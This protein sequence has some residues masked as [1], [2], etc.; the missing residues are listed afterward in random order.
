[1]VSGE[2]FSKNS[3]ERMP[4]SCIFS[5]WQMLYYKYDDMGLLARKAKFTGITVDTV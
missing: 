1:M 2:M 5:W 3:L 4:F